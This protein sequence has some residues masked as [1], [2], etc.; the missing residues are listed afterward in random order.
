MDNLKDPAYKWINVKIQ[1][2]H[3][4]SADPEPQ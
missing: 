2:G 4:L 3:N 1:L